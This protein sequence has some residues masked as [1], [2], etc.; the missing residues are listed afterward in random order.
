MAEFRYNLL[1]ANDGTWI[2]Y[3]KFTGRI[4]EENG[5]ICSRLDFEEA[6]NLIDDM[7]I[8]HIRKTCLRRR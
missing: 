5:A 2:I 6:D 7:N 4:A 8:R 3:D 1:D